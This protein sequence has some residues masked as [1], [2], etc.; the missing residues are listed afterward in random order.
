VVVDPE[1]L[2]VAAL[3]GDDLDVIGVGAAQGGHP[4]IGE[5]AVWIV[6]L[7]GRRLNH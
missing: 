1:A 6:V 5:G 2:D 7:N 3:T 4:T